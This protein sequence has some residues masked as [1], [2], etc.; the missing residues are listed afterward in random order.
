VAEGMN[1]LKRNLQG[2][3]AMIICKKWREL[4]GFAA[5]KVGA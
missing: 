3:W 5:E 1:M 4:L 2:M